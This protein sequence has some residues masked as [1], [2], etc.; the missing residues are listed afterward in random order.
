MHLYKHYW[1]YLHIFNQK[2]TRKYYWMLLSAA[3]K[4]PLLKIKHNLTWSSSMSKLCKA[5]QIFILC[6]VI[7]LVQRLQRKC[8][9]DH[10]W[11]WKWESTREHN[12]PKVMSISCVCIH[13]FCTVTDRSTL[14][15][16]SVS[17]LGDPSVPWCTLV[18][19]VGAAVNSE[20]NLRMGNAPPWL[21]IIH[22]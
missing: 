19:F 14:P 22:N 2:L 10:S 5:C 18:M 3:H 16:W 7:F 21:F 6:D 4:M 1:H 11:D 17:Q 20:W 8:D 15:W 12:D 9:I 13:S